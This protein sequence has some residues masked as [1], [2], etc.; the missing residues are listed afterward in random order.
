M[1]KKDFIKGLKNEKKFDRD[2]YKNI[3]NKSIDSIENEKR[4]HHALIICMEEMAELQK[5]ISKILRGKGDNFN[6][7]E[8]VADVLISI[9][10]IQ[11]II[12]FSDKDIISAINTKIDRLNNILLKGERTL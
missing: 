9:G 8:E 10:Y 2:F 12:H 3:I 6:L 1:N 7:L 5:E 11:E 4:G